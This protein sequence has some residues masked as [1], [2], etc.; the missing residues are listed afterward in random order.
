MKQFIQ[1]IV[2]AIVALGLSVPDHKY[3]YNKELSVNTDDV[4]RINIS[5]TEFSN[6]LAQIPY[7][8]SHQIFRSGIVIVWLFVPQLHEFKETQYLK[9]SNDRDLEMQ[10]SV[11]DH[12]VNITFIR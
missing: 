3:S 7:Y 1:E 6:L 12:Q 5:N 2:D 9:L 11:V 10:I 8:G 4:L